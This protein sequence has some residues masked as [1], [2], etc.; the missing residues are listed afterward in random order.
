MIFL[1]PV[2]V[3]IT[4]LHSINPKRKCHFANQ[5]INEKIIFRLIDLIEMF[6]AQ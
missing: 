2:N 5:T 4:N 3:K 1:V 6:F